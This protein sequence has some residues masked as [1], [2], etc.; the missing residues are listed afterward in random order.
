MYGIFIQDLPKKKHRFLSRYVGIDISVHAMG[1]V[2]VPWIWESDQSILN[3]S[4]FCVVV[5]IVVLR[6]K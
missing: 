5:R 1:L 2:L 4:F 6:I 3:K